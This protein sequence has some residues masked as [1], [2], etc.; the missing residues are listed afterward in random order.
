[1]TSK[2]AATNEVQAAGQGTPKIWLPGSCHCGAVKFEVLHESLYP[3]Q[4]KADPVD[5]TSC[6]CSICLKNGYLFI[7]PKR[8]EVKWLSGWETMKNYRFLTKTKDHKFCDTCGS[9][10]VL[11]FPE[12]LGFVGINVSTYFTWF[13]DDYGIVKRGYIL[14]SYRWGVPGFCWRTRRTYL[15]ATDNDG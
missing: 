11:D 13:H 1:M 4:G 12:N 7:Y 10:V 5:V 8:Q 2:L 15:W 6:N 14:E 3:I 9:S